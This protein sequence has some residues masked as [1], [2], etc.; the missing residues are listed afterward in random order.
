VD[1]RGARVRVE[2]DIPARGLIGLRTR[3]LNATGGEAVMEHSFLDW[4][5]LGAVVR[6][7]LAGVLIATEPGPVTTFALQNL[8]DRGVMFVKPGDA[9]YEGMIVGEHTRENDLNVNV[10]KLKPLSNVRESSKEATVVLKS[11][12]PLTLE[13]ALEYIEDDEYAE[14]TPQSIRIRKRILREAERRRA[15]RQ[16]RDREAAAA[17]QE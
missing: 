4:R 6:K 8:A 9:V 7:R 17:M 12:R 10:V 11:P 3:L 1:M 2:G 14:V 5:P 13:S 16:Q 15:E